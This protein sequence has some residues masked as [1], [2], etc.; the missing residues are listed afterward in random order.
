M[1]TMLK[2]P[3][4][5]KPPSHLNAQSKALWLSLADEYGID[6]TAGIVLLTGVCECHERVCLARAMIDREGPIVPDRWGTPK[7]HP[8]VAVERDARSALLASLRALNL[9]IKPVADRLGRPGKG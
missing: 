8:A 9:D 3:A 6:D 5:P 7:T 1:K 4:K 2:L